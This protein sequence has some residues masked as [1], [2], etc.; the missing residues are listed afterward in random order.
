MRAVVV[1]ES[2]YGNTHAIADAIGRGF[3]RAAQVTVVPVDEADETLLEGADLLVVGGPTHAHG[4]SRPGTRKMA[5]DAAKKPTSQVVLDPAAQ[6]ICLRDWF[7]GLSHFRGAAAAFD[8][9]LH[10]A[11]LLTGRASRR[12]ARLLHRHGYEV[13]SSPE[14]FFV[15]KEGHLDGGEEQRAQQWGRH[16]TEVM[17]ARAIRGTSS[18][19]A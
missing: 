1:Y 12:I 9:R 13:V 17:E 2:M 11:G 19:A 10:G 4:M 3:G 15:S 14:S 7:D 6:G 8:T 5:I 16:L 18:A